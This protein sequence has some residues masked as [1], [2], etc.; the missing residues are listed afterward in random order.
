MTSKDRALLNACLGLIA[1]VRTCHED[2]WPR[3]YQLVEQANELEREI[4][5]HMRRGL[6]PRLRA[7]A[8]RVRWAIVRRLSPKE[9][10]LAR[11]QRAVSEL[12]NGPGCGAKGKGEG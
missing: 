10:R 7:V 6:W 8:G 4:K 1:D 3:P 12:V 11:A 2:G 5:A 9:R